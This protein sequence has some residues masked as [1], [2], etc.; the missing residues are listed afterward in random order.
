M[1]A[2][3]LIILIG[4]IIVLQIINYHKPIEV[5]LEYPAVMYNDEKYESTRVQL[6]IV[7]KRQLFS[8][9]RI[10]GIIL[11]G[12]KSCLVSNNRI[13]HESGTQPTTDPR[14]LR[15]ILWGKLNNKVLYFNH[16]TP[17]QIPLIVELTKRSLVRYR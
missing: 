17:S 12:E 9:D 1:N 16:R 11:M 7:V 6:E 10:D 2:G 15:Q 14:S 4:V 13:F 8:E 3:L 5:S